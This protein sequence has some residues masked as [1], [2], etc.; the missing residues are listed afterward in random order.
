ME[1]IALYEH[2]LDGILEVVEVNS[3][4]YSPASKMCKVVVNKKDITG[5]AVNCV[6]TN[7]DLGSLIR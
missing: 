4:G 2:S 6:Y 7:V 3:S 1:V 5:K